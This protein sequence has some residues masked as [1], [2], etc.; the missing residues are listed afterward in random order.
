MSHRRPEML[1]GGA[2]WTPW[3]QDLPCSGAIRGS[4]LWWG[5]SGTKDTPSDSVQHL[6]EL[7][8]VWGQGTAQPC[9]QA[10]VG[11]SCWA[12]ADSVGITLSLRPPG[13]T[14]LPACAGNLNPLV[15]FF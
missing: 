15:G 4:S 8:Q 14:G 5:Q 13:D 7:P 12:A 2:A 1:Q 3:Y 9:H 6:Q 10:R 11:L